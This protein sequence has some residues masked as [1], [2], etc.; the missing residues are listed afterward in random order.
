MQEIKTIIQEAKEN[1]WESIT[2]KDFEIRELPSEFYEILSLK[3]LII[4]N[5][6]HINEIAVNELLF[7]IYD[8]VFSL[9]SDIKKLVNLEKLVFKDTILEKL[10]SEISLLPNL[11]IIDFTRSENFINLWG[12]RVLIDTSNLMPDKKNSLFFPKLQKLNIPLCGLPEKSIFDSLEEIHIYN[13][14]EFPPI[15]NF[16]YFPKL[17]KLFIH[18]GYYTELPEGLFELERLETLF[19]SGYNNKT[20]PSR[21]SQ[22]KNLKELVLDS[23]YL[24]SLPAE[25]CQLTH[26]QLLDLQNTEISVIPPEMGQLDLLWDN[27]GLSVN[28]LY[29]QIPP[30]SVINQGQKCFNEYYRDS[31][32]TKP[33]QNKRK[34]PPQEPENEVKTLTI[35]DQTCNKLPKNI[36]K[37]TNLETLSYNYCDIKNLSAMLEKLSHLKELVIQNCIL[38]ELP[39]EILLLSDLV[40]LELIHTSLTFIP[41]FIGNLVNLKV[42]KL[43]DTKISDLPSSIG[44]LTRLEELDLS[45]TYIKVIPDEIK[46]LQNLKILDLS[47]TNIKELPKF[48]GSFR[49]LKV[50][51]IH[52]TQIQSFAN[53]FN[54]LKNIESLDIS[55][56][57]LEELPPFVTNQENL[58]RLILNGLEIIKQLPDDFS[59]LSRLEDLSIL[60]TGIAELPFSSLTSLVRLI[61]SGSRINSISKSI[62]NLHNLEQLELSQL[63]IKELP[64][65]IGNL[66][67][68]SFLDLSMTPEITLPDNIG[69][70]INLET[71][72]LENSGIKELPVT[73]GNL[74]NLKVI[75]MYS[76]GIRKIPLEV[77]LLPKMDWSEKDEDGPYDEDI[78]EKQYNIESEA[79][80]ENILDYYNKVI[81]IYSKQLES[82]QNNIPYS[83]SDRHHAQIYLNR[84]HFYKKRCEETNNT[85]DALLAL[86]DF[87]KCTQIYSDDDQICFHVAQNLYELGEYLEALHLITRAIELNGNDS[88]LYNL[89]GEI[90]FD[91]QNYSKAAEQYELANKVKSDDFYNTARYLESCILAGFFQVALK[92]IYLPVDKGD[93]EI[94]NYYIISIFYSLVIKAITHSNYRKE[95]EILIN[96]QKKNGKIKWNR[97]RFEKWLEAIEVDLSVKKVISEYYKLLQKF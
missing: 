48:I 53:E 6:S 5:E 1:L 15:N 92:R 27:N 75:L 19:I 45:G 91:L 26:L 11:T 95:K 37:L 88:C 73:M 9:S 65:T 46:N 85:D 94:D 93:Y 97:N 74:I 58:K 35:V 33:D 89:K 51:N 80:Y 90:Y 64:D 71:L 20:L 49:A 2:I 83:Y 81:T 25:I 52:S 22:L 17:K 3:E 82:I 8:L 50:L 55:L 23:I 61:L 84:G 44:K 7:S 63:N 76:S 31:L 12:A 43:H 40:V 62:G 42:L 68:L 56:T 79:D 72:C 4:S 38:D 36:H 47:R 30:P 34:K 16:K 70:C 60:N 66:I 28:T 14:N 57:K 86:D 13:S 29:C 21:V 41:D 18:C 24:S 59:R 78:S 10:P 67:N 54:Q 32:A 39:E 87:K 77:A 96:T 69:N